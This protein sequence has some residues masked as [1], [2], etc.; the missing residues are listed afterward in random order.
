MVVWGSGAAKTRIYGEHRDALE[1]AVRACEIRSVVD[2]GTHA[3]NRP[4]AICGAHVTALG[5]A[6]P[7]MLG[8]ALSRARLGM[9]R[10][11]PRFLGKSSIFAAFCAHGLPAL[12]LWSAND[13][14]PRDGLQAG[15]H[16]I[17][18]DHDRAPDAERLEQIAHRAAQ[19]YSGHDSRAHADRID[20]VLERLAAMSQP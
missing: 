19:W 9:F 1:R 15:V 3:P 17:E 2:I 7:S 18:C 12:P 8:E 14:D 16:Y 13:A 11:P 20:F 10:Y 5:V 4:A 6:A